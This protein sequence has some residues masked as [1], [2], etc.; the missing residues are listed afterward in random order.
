MMKY[1]FILAFLG[2]TLYASI[3]SSGIGFDYENASKEE[4][5]EWLDTQVAI[6]KAS[7]ARE[8]RAKYGYNSPIKITDMEAANGRSLKSVL[9]LSYV[10][11]RQEAYRLKR[12]LREVFC[13]RY[14][15]LPIADHGLVVMISMQDLD[16]KN[17][18]RLT[19]GPQDCRRYLAENAIS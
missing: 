4:R 5:T 12:E 13:P 3:E 9:S 16:Q 14:N 2:V 18:G 6:T 11:A 17:V 10:D 7:L 8:L 15:K 19:L 1:V